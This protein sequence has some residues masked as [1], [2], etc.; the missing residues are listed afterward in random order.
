[1][2]E[3][4]NTVLTH[5]DVALRVAHLDDVKAAAII[6]TGATVEELDEAI[7]WAAGESDTMGELGHPLSGVTAQVFDILTVSE[8]IAQEE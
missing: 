5:D 7:A 3:R 4:K 8:V 6:A 2:T 1:M